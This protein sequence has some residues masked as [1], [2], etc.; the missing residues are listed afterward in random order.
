MLDVLLNGRSILDL[1]KLELKT[2][3]EATNFIKAYGFDYSNTDDVN[4]LWSFFFEAISFLEK[5]LKDPEHLKIPEHLKNQDSVKDLRRVL[6]MASQ[7]DNHPDQR[8]C[9]AILRVM[10]VLVHLT[11][12]PRL[13]YFDQVRTQIFSRLD[14][15]LF[16]DTKDGTVYLGTAE[17]GEKIKLLYFKKK[18]KKDRERE[19]IKLLH[20][21][22]SVAEDIYDRIG[23]RFVTETKYEA[24]KAVKLLL[25]K[26]I[27]SLANLRPGRSRNRLVDFDRFSFEVKR[28]ENLL[29]TSSHKMS[30]NKIEKLF[31]R[32]ERRIYYRGSSKNL[33]NPYSSE[34]FRSIQFTCREIIKIKN[35]EYQ[36]FKKVSERVENVKEIFSKIP[37]EFLH[38]IFPYEVQIL[39]VKAYADSIFGKSNHDEYRRKQIESARNRVFGRTFKRG[40]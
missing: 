39:D 21:A 14:R 13:Q 10:H 30:A 12:D 38:V 15:F 3:E 36:I 2:M 28:I 37:T 29:Q 31:Q 5:S 17:N 7:N 35:P 25:E 11:L 26:N 18:D 23:F 8:Y 19:I 33:I 40:K 34:T 6:L 16:N 27:I 22:E 20:K 1:P 24:L 9:C 32:L 4:L